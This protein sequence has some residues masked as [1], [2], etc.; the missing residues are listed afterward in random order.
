MVGIAADPPAQGTALDP[1]AANEQD[2]VATYWQRHEQWSTLAN[3]L[4]ARIGF[5]R[6][7]SLVLGAA[8]AL[9]QTAAVAL[10]SG[11]AGMSVSVVGA[12]ALLFVPFIARYFLTPEQVRQWLR[13]RSMSE[14]LKSLVFRFRARAAPFAEDDRVIKLEDAGK[15]AESWVEALAGELAG[16]EDRAGTPPPVLDPDAY[17]ERRVQDQIDVYYRPSA[18]NNASRARAFRRAE[19]VMAALAAALGG[20]T[21]ALKIPAAGVSTGLGPWV[22]VLTTIGGAIAA[23]AAASRYDQQARV[24][25]ATARQLKD[26]VN[27]WTAHGKPQ[28]PASWS[29]FVTACEQAISAENRGWMAKLDPEEQ[30]VVAR[31][32]PGSAG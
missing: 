26:L 32:P 13:A 28:D 12:V 27:E 14:G 6:T 16:V 20:V 22:A 8:G 17:I 15:R 21:A 2:V 30:G 4:K 9:L 25:F 23:H 5:W 11:I 3:R 7:T 10:G 1:A 18:R 29:S 31:P 19:L 24:Y